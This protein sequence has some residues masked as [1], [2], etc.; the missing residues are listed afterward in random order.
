MNL[1]LNVP[2]GAI[3]GLLGANGT[4]KTTA[5]RLLTGQ[6]RPTS[7]MALLLGK[8]R[9]DAEMRKRVGFPPEPGPFDRFATPNALLHRAGKQAGRDAETQRRRIPELL[10][11]LGLAEA[12]EAKLRDLSDG[13]QQRVGLALALLPD[14]DLL[15]LD[16][17]MAALDP[18]GRRDIREMLLE[19]QGRGKTTLLASN[20]LS[21]MELICSQAALLKN[22]RIA[23]QGTLDDLLRISATVEIEARN[24]NDAALRAVREIAAKIRLGHVPITKFSAT[25]RDESDIP[26]LARAIVANGAELVALVPRRET[27]EERFFSLIEE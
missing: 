6:E 1:T 2:E 20:A 26:A 15:I 17:P 14:P 7:G 21:D 18:S 25:L 24:L 3:F 10:E 5:I 4:G 27:L 8:P 9:G 23:A 22:G 13:L 11:R 12:A 16:E 19:A